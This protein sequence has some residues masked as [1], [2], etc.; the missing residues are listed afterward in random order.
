MGDK[1]AAREAAIK[2]GKFN[3]SINIFVISS[4]VFYY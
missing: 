2:A 3:N 1:V 4:R